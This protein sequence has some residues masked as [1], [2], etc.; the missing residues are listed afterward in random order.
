MNAPAQRN[1][2]TLPPHSIEA[3]QSLLG[4]LLLDFRAWDR[5]AD[6]LTEA[7]FYRDDHRRI[8]R[9]LAV[10]SNA[11]KPVDVVT[12]FE[13]IEQSN[14]VDQTG[15]LG[16]LGTL[17][18]SAVSVANI[19]RHAEIIR[20]RAVL[21]KVGAIGDALSAAC[22]RPSVR[23]I[24]AIVAEAEAAIAEALDRRA[25]EPTGLGDVLGEALNYIDTRGEVGGLRTG[26][27]DFDGMTGGLEPGQLVIVAAR[28]SMGKTVF[29]CNVAANVAQRGAAVLLMTLEMT[30]REI[31]MRILAARSGVSM[32]AMRSG[33]KDD[34]A[35]KRMSSE[36]RPANEQRL[37][38]DDTASATVGYV[39]ARARRLKRSKGLDLIVIDYLGLM[40]GTGEN[41]TQ[42]IG[43]I[44][45]GLKALAKELEV[46]II[47][48]S[49]LNRGVE[50]RQDKRPMMSDLRDSGEVE[51][52]ADIVAMLHR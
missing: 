6:L 8:F 28:P 43:S 15:G 5:V 12:V 36:L 20:E 27:R 26:F 47:V 52:D 10:L 41:R 17:A 13:S 34:G 16:Y 1:E 2:I 44:S 49:Q 38:I 11:G 14:E 4:G 21:R 42:E 51:Q 18:N 23:A 39:R 46:P 7:D 45:R 37:W 3:E 35:W 19:R 9:H 33:T 29:G 50:G 30:R 24:E 48:L 32:H 22:Y 31:G 25:S 40:R